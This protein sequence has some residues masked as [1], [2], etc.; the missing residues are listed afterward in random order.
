[1][2][3]QANAAPLAGADPVL[4]RDD[5]G[6]VRRLSRPIA[7]IPPGDLQGRALDEYVQEGDLPAANEA[8]VVRLGKDSGRWWR[9]NHVPLAE[10]SMLVCTDVDRQQRELAHLRE[11]ERLMR[12]TEGMSHIGIWTWD[13][14]QPHAE[15]TPELYR[16]YGLDS[17]KHTPTY[18]DYLTRVHP[19]DVAHVKAATEACFQ[20]HTPYSH[21]ERIRHTDGS[22]RYLHT[23]ARPV[24][25]DDG[26]LVALHG[27]CM[28][29]TDRKHAEL[30]LQASE[31]RLGAIVGHA[32]LGIATV[33]SDGHVR[34]ANAE[35]SKL[36][37]P[38]MDKPLWH[39]M[40][41]HAASAARQAIETVLSRGR[42]H[43]ETFAVDESHVRLVLTRVDAEPPFVVAVAQDVSAQ[44]A[45]DEARSRIDELEAQ[46][47]EHVR[48]VGAVSHEMKNPLTPV[49]IQLN[50]LS[51][52]RLGELSEQQA[53]A[54][55]RVQDQVDRLSG[56]LHE[57]LD[58][59]RAGSGRLQLHFSPVDLS[60]VIEDAV[61]THAPAA[62]DYHLS[63]SCDVEPSLRAVA[64]AGRIAQAVDNLVANAIRF[65]AD[66]GHI[67][68]QARAIHDDIEIRVTDDGV[69]IPEEQQKS[70]FKAFSPGDRPA[71]HP[72]KSTGLG[73]Y[74]VRGIIEGHGGQVAVES[75]DA[76]STFVLRFPSDGP[77]PEPGT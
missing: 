65:T 24:L 4:L 25:D 69:G 59:A 43:V 72:G 76:G 7:G 77:G 34:D 46:H 36:L 58:A 44:V 18:E 54:V 16:I 74:V 8:A 13:I 67:A 27:V 3:P 42:S 11:A 28:D 1:M 14:T 38:R 49:M 75:S 37:H 17:A 10:G 29:I 31:E 40:P 63:L 60:P 33:R 15:W 26:Q 64:D 39:A 52:G 22:W 55:Q 68:I 41:M 9:I 53:T 66:G 30:A 62:Q 71:Q 73:L 32:G 6:R 23:W 57:L 35:F 48:M 19:D 70:L 45:A 2:L 50:L 21:D 61:A 12:D 20:D 5:K 51:S 47:S 56:M